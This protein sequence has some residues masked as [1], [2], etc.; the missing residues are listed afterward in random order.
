[1]RKYAGAMS[2][3]QAQARYVEIVLQQESPDEQGYSQV[4]VGPLKTVVA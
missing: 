1:M 4:K 3:R 2:D